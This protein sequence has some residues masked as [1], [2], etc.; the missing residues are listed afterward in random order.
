VPTQGNRSPYLD[1]YLSAFTS[2]WTT[3]A[4]GSFP[5]TVPQGRH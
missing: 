4:P 5:L 1:R 2:T 3:H